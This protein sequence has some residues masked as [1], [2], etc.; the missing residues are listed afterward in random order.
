MKI[1]IEPYSFRVWLKDAVYFGNRLGFAK[2]IDMCVF[3]WE[4]SNYLMICGISIYF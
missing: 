1:D 2:W 3:R 4:K